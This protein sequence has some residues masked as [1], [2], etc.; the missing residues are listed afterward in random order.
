MIAGERVGLRA[1]AR[2]LPDDERVRRLVRVRAASD[3]ALLRA[4]VG[5][6][7]GRGEGRSTTDCAERAFG[8]E[9]RTLR[10][11]LTE[12]QLVLPDEI[13]TK[14]ERLAWAFGVEVPG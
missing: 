9:P 2:A 11:W 14:V 1:L 4:V 6:G 7:V 12:Q 13:R 8:V 3:L 5:D 10:R